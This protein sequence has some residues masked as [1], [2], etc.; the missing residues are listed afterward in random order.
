MSHLQGL[1]HYKRY[2]LWCTPVDY[3]NDAFAV[4]CLN[5]GWLYL[6]TKLIDLLDTV[7]VN[8]SNCYSRLI[9]AAFTGFLCF[10]EKGQSSNLSASLSSH[11]DVFGGDV[12]CAI[13]RRWPRFISRCNKLL[14]ACLDVWILFA[15]RLL[16]ELQKE[17]LVEEIHNNVAI[18]K[19]EIVCFLRCRMWSF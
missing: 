1:L 19:W 5:M 2:N 17:Y 3:S 16:S 6:F 11:N 4:F 14:R 8:W 9:P 18:S 7:I 15:F 10:E 12:R 13:R